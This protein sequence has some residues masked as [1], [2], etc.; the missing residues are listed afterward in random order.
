MISE[1]V[2]DNRRDTRVR[3]M[4]GGVEQVGQGVAGSVPCPQT[5]SP[6][7]HGSFTGPRPGHTFRR[8]R[9][10]HNANDPAI[11]RVSSEQLLLAT[12]RLAKLKLATVRI[13][14]DEARE[15]TPAM[16]RAV[17]VSGWLR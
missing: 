10:L 15:R 9:T 17:N 8:P 11:I 6:A 4:L 5:S 12:Q 2:R 1:S 14:S 7:C 3:F 13:S 16:E